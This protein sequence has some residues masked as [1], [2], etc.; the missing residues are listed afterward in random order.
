MTRIDLSYLAIMK[1]MLPFSMQLLPDD[2]IFHVIKPYLDMVEMRKAVIYYKHYN[3]AIN[4]LKQVFTPNQIQEH[5]PMQLTVQFNE[6]VIDD[7]SF[8]YLKK[9]I[10]CMKRMSAIQRMLKRRFL[11]G[12]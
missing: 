11:H 1:K 6:L 8:Q 5:F 12:Y 9:H 10:C 2:I 7:E 4:N 3:Y